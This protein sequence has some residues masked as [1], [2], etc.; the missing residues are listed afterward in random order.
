MAIYRRSDYEK[1][2]KHIVEKTAA[3][4]E[5]LRKMRRSGGAFRPKDRNQLNVEGHVVRE[6]RS[7]SE[8][9]KKTLEQ[10]VGQVGARIPEVQKKRYENPR[11]F[12]REMSRI[13]AAEKRRD[14]VSERRNE[15]RG[16][17]SSPQ[18]YPGRRPEAS[19][20]HEGARRPESRPRAIIRPPRYQP[21]R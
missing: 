5:D 6:V 18:D 21:P 15:R 3:R 11:I 8:M 4:E 19:H 1:Y 7:G 14:H 17:R 10:V 20:P 2:G 12:R 13:R 9:E 16:E